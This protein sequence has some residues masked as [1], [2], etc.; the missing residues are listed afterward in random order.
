MTRI[1][2]VITI[3]LIGCTSEKK[4]ETGKTIA[5][6]DQT[7]QLNLVEQLNDEFR[8]D[9]LIYSGEMTNDDT[10]L[11]PGAPPN[12][13][14]LV[15]DSNNRFAIRRK[16]EGGEVKTDSMTIYVQASQSNIGLGRWSDLGEKF[17]LKLQ[18]GGVSSFFGDERNKG[19]LDIVG[20]RTLQLDKNV[21]AI[22]IGGVLCTRDGA[23]RMNDY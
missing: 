12:F 17:E 20:N 14:Q 7:E 1:L 4:T 18:I 19:R 9:V 3:L 21:D 10:G 5:D 11:P 23:G 15:M 22:W 2:T 13:I 6:L 16:F 8:G